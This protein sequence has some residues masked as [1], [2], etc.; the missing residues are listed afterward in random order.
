MRKPL[1]A[2][3]L[4]LACALSLAACSDDSPGPSG[5]ETT[6]GDITIG[7]VVY[8]FDDTFMSSMREAMTKQASSAGVTIDIQDGLNDQARENELVNNFVTQGVDVLAINPVKADIIDPVLQSAKE[9]GLPIVFFNKQPS[10][11]VMNSYDKAYYVGAKAEDSG[12]MMGEILAEYFKDYPAADKNGDG[13]IQFVMLTGEINHQDAVLRS[14]YSQQALQDAG[15]ISAGCFD[16]NT[17]SQST[18]PNECMLANQTANWDTAAATDLMN[19]WITSL[20]L[21]NIEA[22]I[23]NNDDMGLGAI[24]ALQA[25]GYN[26]TGT[27]GDPAKYIPV[28]AVDAT[29]KGKA[30]LAAGSLLGT[31]LNDAVN[32]GQAVVNLSIAAA[33]GDVSDATVGYPITDGKF[34]WIPYVKV[35]EA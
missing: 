16:I 5:T 2:G 29:D 28:V 34:I 19:N 32:Q 33:R 15:L 8:K 30:A 9:A 27:K 4:G 35:T 31:V 10:D 3:F 24:A 17:W 12:T 7:S 6:G 1:I 20:G 25:N 18:S 22:V 14:Q 21:E 26:A 13:M 11:T 23:A